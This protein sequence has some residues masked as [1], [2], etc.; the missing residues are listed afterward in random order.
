MH[1]TDQIQSLDH[2]IEY[3]RTKNSDGSLA[4]GLEWERS[5]VYDQTWL[6]VTYFGEKGYKTILEELIKR[7]GWAE[8]A[9]EGDVIKAIKRGHVTVT[10]ESD[11]RLELAGSPEISLHYLADEFRMHLY[12]VE[13]ISKEMGIRWVPLGVQPF[14]AGED[15]EMV[16]TQRNRQARTLGN[17]EY[18]LPYMMNCNG[19]H[20]NYGYTSEDN[21]IKKVQTAMRLVPVVSVLF[22]T[23]PL[24]KGQLTEYKNFRR[25]CT[26]RAVPERNGL[27]STLMNPDFDLRQWLEFIWQSEVTIMFVGNREVNPD[28]LTFGQW[29]SEGYQGHY[30]QLKDIDA[31]IK[32]LWSDIRL[33][34]GY[35]EFRAIDSLPR[36]LVM[37]A[38]AFI[39][40]LVFDSESWATIAD[41]FEGMSFDDLVAFDEVCWKEGL[42]ATMPNGKPIRTLLNQLLELSSRK[43]SEFSRLNHIDQDESILLDPLRDLAF[44]RKATVADEIIAQWENDWNQNPEKLI[45]YCEKRR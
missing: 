35:I 24:F 8:T 10:I 15:F 39:K 7:Y 40:G 30:P 31:Q 41:L 4:M 16:P 19:I 43:L 1:K 22:A 9:R 6:P 36:W 14:A 45:E 32:T 33:R 28:N 44:K 3:Y 34:P 29:V 42:E 13:T 38:A 11:G 5:A 25:V 2:A 12:E 37:A 17:L 20:I 26:Q 27:P 23:S 21:L 18:M